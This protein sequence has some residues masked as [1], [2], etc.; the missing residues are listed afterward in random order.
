MFVDNDRCLPV[1]ARANS[2]GASS[3]K[4]RPTVWS[5]QE[6]NKDL[7]C[8]IYPFEH[9]SHSLE[10]SDLLDQWVAKIRLVYILVMRKLLRTGIHKVRP[11]VLSKES[12]SGR[13]SAFTLA[14]IVVYGVSRLILSPTHR[15]AFGVG[16]VCSMRGEETIT[17]D[18]NGTASGEGGELKLE[19][20]RRTMPPP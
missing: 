10:C 7:E 20:K 11:V 4:P 5:I 12:E 9:V 6:D 8:Q 1:G 14:G 3:A 15:A 18:S 2:Y 16:R 17:P 13:T 19:A